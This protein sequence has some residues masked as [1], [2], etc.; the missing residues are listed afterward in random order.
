[1]LNCKVRVTLVS[2]LSLLLKVLLI[3]EAIKIAA[4]LQ[5]RKYNDTTEE[6]G[7]LLLKLRRGLIHY[8]ERTKI[9]R[10]VSERSQ[11][12]ESMIFHQ[13]YCDHPGCCYGQKTVVVSLR[14][15]T[16]CTSQGFR[17]EKES[18]E[19]WHSGFYNPSY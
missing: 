7:K 11:S 16:Y 2:S 19:T 4:L 6:A 9:L 15:N 10:T 18:H 13:S 5:V 17:V 8:P 3:S 14:R 12:N 1:M